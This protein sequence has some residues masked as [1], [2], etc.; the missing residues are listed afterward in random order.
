MRLGTILDLAT[1]HNIQLPA[2]DAESLRPFV[3][4]TETKSDLM[5][6][7][8]HFKYLT[9]VMVNPEACR[10][11]AFENVLDAAAEGIGYIEL[12]FSPVFMAETHGLSAADVVD[13]VV[14]GVRDGVRETGVDARLIGILSR[15]YGAEC[16]MDELAALLRRKDGLVAIDL[17][18]NEKSFPAHLF[19]KHF[20]KVR[21]ADLAYT[22]HAGEADGPESVWS[23]I[24]DLGAMRIG[25]GFR[26]IEDPQL[27][28]YLVEHRIGLEI[29]L[30]SNL[31][32]GAV[33]RYAAHPA[34]RLFDAGVLLNLNTDNPVISGIDLPH[35]YGPAADQAG[36]DEQDKVQL[37]KNAVEMAF[38]YV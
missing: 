28:D 34:R 7:I 5:A 10:R 36:F 33:D 3:E 15:S 12:R 4:I 23:A 31:Q 8:A 9:A 17:A 35:E 21:E 29:C 6:F 24:K 16:C 14:D 13:A 38:D 18:G 2:N 20:R 30:T 25:H 37:R 27:V 26:S 32:I 19:T 11:I 1:Q 22:I